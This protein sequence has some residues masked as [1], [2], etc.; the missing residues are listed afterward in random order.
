MDYLKYWEL[1]NN[2]R[3][4]YHKLVTTTMI[5]SSTEQYL[6]FGCVLANA[7]LLSGTSIT[8]P[9]QTPTEKLMIRPKARV[10]LTALL[11][12]SYTVEAFVT[13]AQTP[14][15]VWFEASLV[16]LLVL[17]LIWS[18]IGLPRSTPRRLI[19]WA[20]II[21]A[22]FEALLL[23]LSSTHYA[24][25]W[26]WIA[27][28]F[29]QSIRVLLLICIFAT[30]PRLRMDNICSEDE[31]EEAR[32]ILQGQAEAD[33]PP[34]YGSRA[35]SDDP[36]TGSEATWL[37]DDEDDEEDAEMKRLRAKR[38]KETGGWWGYLKDF[39]IFIP[40]LIPRRNLKVQFAICVS[41]LSLAA[42]RVLNILMPRQLGIVTDQILQ[43]GAPYQALAVWLVLRLLNSPSGVGIVMELSKIPIQQFSYRQISNAA[44]SH[45]MGLSMEFHSER[46]SA[47]VMKAIEQGEALT[48]ILDTA[49]LEILPTVVDWFI[50]MWLLYW[51]FNVYLALAMLLASAA[52]AALEVTTSRWNIENRRHKA[53]AQREESRVMHQAVQG[54]QTVTYFNMFTF[55]RLRFGKAV[56]ER[57]TANRNWA[58]RDTWTEAVLQA[59]AP[60]TF[61]AMASL[62]IYEISHGMATPG[63][64]VFLLEYWETLIWPLQYL[65]HNYRYLMGDLIDAERL[66]KLLQTK[67]T[68]VDKEGAKPLSLMK[69]HVAFENVV[70]S[71]DARKPAIQGVDIVANPGDTVAFVGETGA[72]KSTILK[73][74]LR[75]YDV[76]SGR[77]A[78]DD[79]DIRDVTLSSV[80]DAFGVV[81]QDPLLFNASI[82]ENLRYARPLATDEQVYQACRAAA[83]HNKI[84]SFPGGYGTKVGEQ[85]VK[86]SGGEIQRLA[87]AR[88][89]LKDPPIL[90][91]D[92][93]TSAV[94]TGT[95]SEIQLALDA[96]K[97]QRTTFLIAHRLSTVVKADQIL[98]VHDGRV[99]ERGTHSELT[100]A[101]GRY[102]ELWA[103]QAGEA[104]EGRE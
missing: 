28:V 54:W 56:E 93:A 80:R 98:V 27:Q 43:R 85:G 84:L 94:D 6:H 31:A 79:Q 37:D 73:L 32:P 38:L 33:H 1:L 60:L 71:Y 65:S 90:I 34:N 47:E 8:H 102:H 57:L 10:G 44:F 63:D 3:L 59:L 101:K 69:G 40:Y 22:S 29:C 55:E 61:F 4:L 7:A 78:I 76:D 26:Q 24:R 48:N 70:F 19:R 83:I 2:S 35:Q 23:A 52:L 18:L 49:I 51:K 50:A 68:I 75:F 41:L 74:L 67:P 12:T 25:G 16:H 96:L 30:E 39:A 15:P 89:F 103:R 45:V 72:G 91:L 36:E 13:V 95:E 64:F 21:T 53:K 86:L 46:D 77:I 97:K 9:S 17:P 11:I 62:A 104:R 5:P 81:P 100:R 42:T 20:C 58:K 82:M 14:A 87:I 66:L 88:V 92:E 99:V